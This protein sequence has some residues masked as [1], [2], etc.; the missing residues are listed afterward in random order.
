MSKDLRLNVEVT[1]NVGG[2]AK[3]VDRLSHTIDKVNREVG[4]AGQG[5]G[6][7]DDVTMTPQKTSDELTKA[8]Q[9][10]K[11]TLSGLTASFR[12]LT[13]KLA[14]IK[15]SPQTQDV[16][17]TPASSESPLSGSKLL[18]AVSMAG[19]FARSYALPAMRASR[20]TESNA[21]SVYA[22]TG[23]YGS[24]FNKARVNANKT[25]SQYG[26]GLSETF[27]IQDSLMGS[28]GFT[29]RDTLNRDTE[30]VMRFSKTFGLSGED[31]SQRFGRQ[32]QRGAFETGEAEKFTNLLGSSVEANNMVGREDEQ[33]RA[34]LDIQDILLG[35]K[36]NVTSDDF[37]DVAN[38]QAKLASINPN[39]RGDRGAE[40]LGSASSLIN[41][42]DE[43]ALRLVGYGS[44]LG[45]GSEA[46][47]RATQMAFEGLANK[48]AVSN[49]LENMPKFGIDPNSAMGRLY[50]SQQTGLSPEKP[51]AL[52]DLMQSGDDVGVDELL[53]SRQQE[54]YGNVEDS[55]ALKQEK[56]DAF[57]E[58]S[59]QSFGN[60]INNIMMPGKEMFSDLPSGL[61]GITRTGAAAGTAYLGGK[62]ISALLKG[63]G[64][65]ANTGNLGSSIATAGGT[66]GKALP[67]VS[68]VGVGLTTAVH[69][70][71]SAYHIYQGDYDKAAGSL[72]ALGGTLAGAKAGAAAGTLVAPGIGTAIGG[73]AGGFIGGLGGRFLGEK[74][75]EAFEEHE[76]FGNFSVNINRQ[77]ENLS[78]EESLIQKQESVFDE[79]LKKLDQLNPPISQGL[80]AK[81]H[82]ELTEEKK[83]RQ[84]NGRRSRLRGL[85]GEGDY[86]GIVSKKE[87]VGDGDGGSIS[88]GV[89]D[90]GGKSYGIPQ[91]TS[92]GGGGSANTFVKSLEDTEFSKFFKGAGVAG[93][94]SFDAAWRN[95]YASNPE[96]FTQKQQEYVYK[97]HIEPFIAATL[98]QKGVDL[99]STRALQE[100]AFSTATQYGGGG[101]YA[102]GDINGSM[103]EEE[104]IRAVQN[105][106]YNNVGTHFRDSSGDVQQ[107]VANRTQREMEA[108]LSMTGQAPIDG[109]AIGADYITKDQLARIHEG[110]TILNRHDAKDYRE[111]KLDVKGNGDGQLEQ[112]RRSQ[113]EIN[114]ILSSAREVVQKEAN[115]SLNVT[116]DGRNADDE[117]MQ[118]VKAAIDQAIAS[119]KSSSGVN[120]NQSFQRVAN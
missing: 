80:L 69:G 46:L 105:H 75:Y 41:P 28:A 79:V 35:E 44:Q 25:G 30:S 23:D 61:Q 58:N 18:T 47:E 95:A 54:L 45:T 5:I 20:A 119:V 74:G 99:S 9:F 94:D 56:F 33:V 67:A 8:Q 108:L 31:I 36:L 24:D 29:S 109:Y 22:R 62:G 81:K 11:N 82:E 2:V 116:L 15:R 40:F 104:I 13:H 118:R 83:A 103:S 102:L 91:F 70:A 43:M 14:G 19:L 93:T 1:S 42:N 38:L 117:L 88:S 112:M 107:S 64:D 66:F 50:V 4:K 37:K 98:K 90:Y 32:V 12:D 53:S 52:L 84:I 92:A 77:K 68:K 27:N 34:L 111:G 114:S 6:G 71:E 96:G 101:Q 87:E 60:L 21:L 49:M 110:E 59:K 113:Q 26:Y 73:L 72:G 86:L 78:K 106:K 39:L 48:E 10:L 3:D 51:G 57:W 16:P 17:Q 120:L 76:T 97:T 63:F 85:G 115:I 100:L 7:N 89:G 65:F 55:K